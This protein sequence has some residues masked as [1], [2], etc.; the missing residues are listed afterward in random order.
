MSQKE[1]SVTIKLYSGIHKELTISDYD[2]SKGIT[3]KVKKGA[4]LKK[5]FKA[6]GYGKTVF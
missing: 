1:I 3:L 4:R 2:L 5:V 6:N